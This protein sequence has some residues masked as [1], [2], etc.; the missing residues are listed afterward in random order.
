MGA[1]VFF[2]KRRGIH[3]DEQISIRLPSEDKEIFKHA[4]REAGWESVSKAMRKFIRY[5]I[6]YRKNPLMEA[7]QEEEKT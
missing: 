5:V 6:K 3:Q 2:V 7:V 1:S 4:C